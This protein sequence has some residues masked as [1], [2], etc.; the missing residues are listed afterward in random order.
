M[1]GAKGA[2]GQA[3]AGGLHLGQ[4][5]QEAGIAG[6]PFQLGQDRTRGC[7]RIARLQ[8]GLGR[9]DRVVDRCAHRPMSPDDLEADPMP[10]TGCLQVMGS[11]PVAKRLHTVAFFSLDRLC[12]LWLA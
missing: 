12:Y 10:G 7:Y 5:G 9:L 2:G 1:G 6:E 4:L 8:R 11:L 3:G